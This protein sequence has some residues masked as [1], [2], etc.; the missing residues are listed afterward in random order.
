MRQP[1]IVI[2]GL[3]NHMTSL[4]GEFKEFI[5]DIGEDFTTF[6]SKLEDMRKAYR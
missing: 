4:F 1:E 2:D 5:T 6:N 3:P